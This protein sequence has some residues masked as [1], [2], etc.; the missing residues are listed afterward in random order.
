MKRRAFFG[1]VGGAAVAGPAM[2]KEAVTKLAQATALSDLQLPYGL[3]YAGETAAAQSMLGGYGMMDHVARAKKKLDLIRGFTAAQRS[4]M[5]A[6]QNVH[7]L[8]PDLASYRS[9]SLAAKIDIQRERMVDKLYQ[10]T[11]Q[12]SSLSAVTMTERTVFV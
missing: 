9:F 6:G 2:A 4:E 8:D 3:G 5:K 11:L 10:T 1:L 7:E 12:R